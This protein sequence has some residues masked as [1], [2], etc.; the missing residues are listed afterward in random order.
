MNKRNKMLN[1]SVIIVL[2]FCLLLQSCSKQSFKINVEHLFGSQVLKSKLTSINTY[3][4]SDDML[5]PAKIELNSIIKRIVFIKKAEV[6]GPSTVRITFSKPVKFLDGHPEWH[7]FAC[8]TPYPNPGVNGSWQ[9]EVADWKSVDVPGVKQGNV[10]VN[11]VKCSEIFEFTFSKPITSDGI[12]RI[13]ESPNI[14]ENNELGKICVDNTNYPLFANAPSNVGYDVTYASMTRKYTYVESV[15]MDYT[16]NNTMLVK[17][18]EP[19]KFYN[20]DIKKYIYASTKQN[21]KGDFFATPSSVTIVEG[22]D[23]KGIISLQVTFAQS[24]DFDF[25]LC[26]F[27]GSGLKNDKDSNGLGGL[28]YST[29]SSTNSASQFT[30]YGDIS[31]GGN[32]RVLGATGNGTDGTYLYN[33]FD[34][35]ATY[36]VSKRPSLLSAQIYSLSEKTVKLTFDGFVHLS[37]TSLIYACDS[38]EPTVWQA[39]P[40]LAFTPIHTNAKTVNGIQYS[41]EVVMRFADV[42]DLK[43]STITNGNMLLSKGVIRITEY[44][45][46][47]KIPGV[48]SSTIISDEKGRGIFANY[49]NRDIATAEYSGE[50][51]KLSLIGATGE[52]VN[53]VSVDFSQKI[54]FVDNPVNYFRI[55]LNDNRELTPVSF[56]VNAGEDKITFRF[57]DKIDSD[58]TAFIL[59]GSKIK[60]KAGSKP[61]DNK[62]ISFTKPLDNPRLMSSEI[63]AGDANLVT[64]HFDQPINISSPGLIYFRND[65]DATKFQAVFD[66]AAY[67]VWDAKNPNNPA[68]NYGN[69]YFKEND[70]F[71]SKDITIKFANSIVDLKTTGLYNNKTSIRDVDGIVAITEYGLPDANGKNRILGSGVASNVKG[72]GLLNNAN[73]AAWD[74]ATSKPS[75]LPDI[76]A[77]MLL[78]AQIIGGNANRVELKFSKPVTINN[79][80]YIFY[81][82]DTNATV[83]QAEFD[84]AAYL[85]AENAANGA[86]NSALD[87]GANYKNINGKYYSDTIIIKFKNAVYYVANSKP[88]ADGYTLPNGGIVAITEYGMSDAFGRNGFVSPSVISEQNGY[89]VKNNQNESYYDFACVAAIPFTGTLTNPTFDKAEVLDGT[90]GLVRLTFSKPVNIMYPGLIYYREEPSNPKYQGTFNYAA[91]TPNGENNP[92]NPYLDYGENYQVIDGK[93][94]SSSII[95]GFTD[96]TDLTDNKSYINLKTLPLGGFVTV[97]EYSQKDANGRDGFVSPSVVRSVLGEGL[98]NNYLPDSYRDFAY[99]STS[100]MLYSKIDSSSPKIVYDSSFAEFNVNYTSM[101]CGSIKYSS[102]NNAIM[103]F[104]FNGTAIRWY[105]TQNGDRA[106][107]EVYIDD[108]LDKTINCGGALDWKHLFYEKTGLS[109]GEHTIKIKTISSGIIDIDFFEVG[110][111]TNAKSVLV[112]DTSITA[113][114]DAGRLQNIGNDYKNTLTYTELKD[115]YFE[116]KFTGVALRYFGRIYG[117]RSLANIYI[118][119]QLVT[120]LDE[121]NSSL[122]TK[123]CVFEIAGLSNTEHTVKIVNFGPIPIRNKYLDIDFLEIGIPKDN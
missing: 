36:V 98:Q 105:G 92:R 20:P 33:G 74:F 9:Y 103:Q 115:G 64:L 29:G 109:N 99:Q 51:A 62:S 85:N 41:K 12:I 101:Y 78:Q 82:N 102:T 24:F 63:L 112:D 14:D 37:N 65:T 54:K 73:S 91:Y 26:F 94:Y 111:V 21:G 71:Y 30:V 38:A 75:K 96:V 5:P 80:G 40:D 107:A 119:G 32:G 114:A 118:D 79:P 19:M 7:L 104:T 57:N 34:V 58:G 11:K 77:P 47:D 49:A 28:A 120:T 13:V 69:N 1:L 43:T 44:G 6:I 17:F 3:K 45:T 56:E 10:E 88:Y 52:D 46:N 61:L 93:F 27:E 39:I 97:T 35:C 23:S 76:D 42:F 66:W 22:N 60:S 31:A 100:S 95:M 53:T 110:N 117:D 84:W 2:I 8:D 81:R 86:R 122:V 25:Y 90:K 72:Q 48:V 68:L 113:S 15:K 4:D 50:S 59:D 18:S 116:Y 83:Y 55:K 89:G 121:Y 16:K 123:S 108:V 87:Y 106:Q 70:K 67:N